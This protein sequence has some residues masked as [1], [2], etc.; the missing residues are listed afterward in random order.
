MLAEDVRKAEQSVTEQDE[1]YTASKRYMVE[2]RG[3]LDPHEMLQS[4][5]LLRQAD[6]VGAL[7]VQTRNRLLKLQD[8]PYF[9]RID[10][11]EGTGEANPCYIGASAY[12][13]DG[14]LFISDWRSPV[15][16]MYYDFEPGEAWYQAPGGRVRG[17]AD[18]EAAVQNP[19]RADG[20][21]AGERRPDSG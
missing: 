13:R 20:I 6:R 15:A 16:G 14:Q 11:R 9:A 7:S 12:L 1:A 2:N 5:L 17:R 4:E 18:A 10:F 8:S 3:E 19:Q 21:R